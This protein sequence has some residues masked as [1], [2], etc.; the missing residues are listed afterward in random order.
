MK[1][2]VGSMSQNKLFIL[3]FKCKNST[4]ADHLI[5]NFSLATN[6]PCDAKL[7]FYVKKYSS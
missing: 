4:S 1:L 7:R 3:L 6:K 2:Y 5:I